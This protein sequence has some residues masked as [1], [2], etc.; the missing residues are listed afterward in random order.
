[1]PVPD[2]LVLLGLLAELD[3]HTADDLESQ[4]L[5]FKPCQGPN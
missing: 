1:M 4:H 5:D 2:S 3:R